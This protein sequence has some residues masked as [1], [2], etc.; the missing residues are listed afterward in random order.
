[1]RTKRRCWPGKWW[2]SD[3]KEYEIRAGRRIC[4]AQIETVGKGLL[5]RKSELLG[6]LD[7][8]VEEPFRIRSCRPAGGRHFQREYLY[9]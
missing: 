7:R 1:M 6:V 2:S 5:N 9:R 8:V 4:I 3:A